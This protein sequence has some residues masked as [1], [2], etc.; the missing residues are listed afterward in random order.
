MS[1]RPIVLRAQTSLIDDQGHIWARFELHGK[2]PQRETCALCGAAIRR[3]YVE[4]VSPDAGSIVPGML[5]ARRICGKHIEV[6]HPAEPGRIERL[7]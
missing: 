6:H 5:P 2:A 4:Y 7:A 3:G 1:S